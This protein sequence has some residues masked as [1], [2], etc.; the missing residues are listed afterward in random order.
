MLTKDK[1]IETIKAMPEEQFEDIDVLL[2]RLVIL[3]K[4]QQGEEDIKAGRVYSNEQMKEIIQSWL[5]SS[6]PN[7]H[8]MT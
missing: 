3:E 8:K 5:P 7:Q 2:E 1:I 4:V 6:G